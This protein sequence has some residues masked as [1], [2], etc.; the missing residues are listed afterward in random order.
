[1]NPISR[2]LINYLGGREGILSTTNTFVNLLTV[3]RVP[4]RSFGSSNTFGAGRT[5]SGNLYP[6]KTLSESS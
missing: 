5:A 6:N 2:L 1:M 4:A 3:T